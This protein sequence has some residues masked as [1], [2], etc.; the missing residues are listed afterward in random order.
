MDIKARSPVVLSCNRQYR[1]LVKQFKARWRTLR[2]PDLHENLLHQIHHLSWRSSA[3]CLYSL[4]STV[5]RTSPTQAS[6]DFLTMTTTAAIALFC[7]TSSGGPIIEADA[8]YSAVEESGICL[9]ASH[10]SSWNSGILGAN[11][12]STKVERKW[13]MHLELKFI[14]GLVGHRAF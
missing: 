9:D 13:R 4:S 5:I 7:T 14:S 10:F 3:V 8:P 6:I 1:H 11:N 12:V 2:I